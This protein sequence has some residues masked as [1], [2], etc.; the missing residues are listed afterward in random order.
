MY[1][2]TPLELFLISKFGLF[3][4]NVVASFYLAL[5]KKADNGRSIWGWS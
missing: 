3:G 1:K 5:N 4:E 2:V